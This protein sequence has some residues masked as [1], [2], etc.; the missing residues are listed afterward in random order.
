MTQPRDE[1]GKFGETHG[2]R[3]AKLAERYTDL[4]TVEGRRLE[5][6]I[7]S[8]AADLG[9]HEAL[10]AGDRVTL[11]LLKTRL[12]VIMRLSDYVDTLDDI[13]GKD[14]NLLSVLS[15]DLI[16]YSE[17]TEKTLQAL[18]KGIDKSRRTPTLEEYLKTRN[19]A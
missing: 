9:G 1:K 6:V 17:S 19:S 8:I 13:I 11:D 12:M 7:T 4:R 15:R 16:R 10:S 5:D 18:Y 14:G 2:I 3:S